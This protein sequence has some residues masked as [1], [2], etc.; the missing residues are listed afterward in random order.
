MRVF[1]ES[2]SRSGLAGVFSGLLLT[3][4]SHRNFRGGLAAIGQRKGVVGTRFNGAHG[5][6][7]RPPASSCARYAA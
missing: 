1:E 2:L 4:N 5:L 7:H 3:A 6:W